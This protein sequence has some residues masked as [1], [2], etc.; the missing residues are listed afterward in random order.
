MENK[1]EVIIRKCQSLE[2]VVR[3]KNILDLVKEEEDKQHLNFSVTMYGAKEK[4]DKFQ[5][6]QL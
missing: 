5:S 4:S 2:H 1:K 3:V 6:G